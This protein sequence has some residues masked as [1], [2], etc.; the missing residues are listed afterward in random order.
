MNDGQ[1]SV[2][3]R[4]LNSSRVAKAIFIDTGVTVGRS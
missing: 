1:N 4:K 3:D 2:T